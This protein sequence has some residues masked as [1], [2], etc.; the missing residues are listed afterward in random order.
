MSFT[1]P[2]PNPVANG[3]PPLAK[4]AIAPPAANVGRSPPN[5]TMLSKYLSKIPVSIGSAWDAF[6]QSYPKFP[7]L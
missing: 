1:N 2:A 7:P 6:F 4:P 3:L 5:P